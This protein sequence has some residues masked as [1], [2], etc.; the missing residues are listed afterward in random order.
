[1]GYKCLLIDK[2]TK[3]LNSVTENNNISDSQS[4]KARPLWDENR[5]AR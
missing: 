5:G 2:K 1:M 3:K 4:S